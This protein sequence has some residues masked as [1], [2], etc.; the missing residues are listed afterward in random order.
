MAWSSLGGIHEIG[1]ESIGEIALFPAAFAFREGL[2]RR[3]RYILHAA[4]NHDF[5][6]LQCVLV[7]DIR[8]LRQAGDFDG[9][10]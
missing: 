2:R 7:F 1:G 8:G 10:P 4:E 3:Q 9:D 5:G 6:E